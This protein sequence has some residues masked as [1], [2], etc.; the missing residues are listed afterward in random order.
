MIKGIQLLR[1][2]AALAVV[3]VHC[4]FHNMETGTFGVDIFFIISGFII[5][6]MVNQTTKHFIIKRIVRVSPL[7]FL[8]TFL[9]VALALVKPQWFNHVIINTEALIKSF[10]FIPYQIKESGPILSLGWTLNNEMFFY[11]V[12]FLCIL[13]FRKKEHLV[14]ACAALLVLLLLVLNSFSKDTI[15]AYSHIL[16]FYRNGLLPEFIYGLGLYYFWGYYSHNKIKVVDTLMVT[17]GLAAFAIMIYFDLNQGFQSIPRNIHYGI[18]SL[19]F[20]NAFLVLENKINIKNRIIKTGLKLGDASYA[21]YLFHPFVLY[22]LVRVVYPKIIGP[23]KL[24]MVELSE[25][26]FAIV[27]VGVVS[28]LIYE[29]VDKPL[30]KFIKKRIKKYNET[31]I[32][33]LAV[34][35]IESQPVI[36]IRR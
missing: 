20:V 7:Y 22:F 25:L 17:I 6:Y 18:P 4:H 21:M 3:F 2:I 30:N 36:E 35:E 24:L 32:T 28:V 5:A 12:M 26:I 34:T 19:L 11:G 23:S 29:F 1:A 33:K 15:S 9:T 31:R 14:P 16:R 10:L 8:A 13:I 27:L